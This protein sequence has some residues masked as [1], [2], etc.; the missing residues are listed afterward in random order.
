MLK[1]T[2]R[3]KGG[4]QLGLP[5]SFAWQRAAKFFYKNI[6]NIKTVQQLPGLSIN[7]ALSPHA[8]FLALE[9]YLSLSR[10]CLSL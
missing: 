2:K 1:R 3:T 5:A 10:N 9:P 8:L 6:F 4:R 7:L